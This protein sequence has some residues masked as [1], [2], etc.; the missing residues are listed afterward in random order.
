MGN[1]HYI[2]YNS[3]IE[4]F[5][6]LGGGGGGGERGS[7]VDQSTNHKIGHHVTKNFTIKG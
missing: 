2:I 1:I 5:F 7:S 4:M 3:Y 6:F